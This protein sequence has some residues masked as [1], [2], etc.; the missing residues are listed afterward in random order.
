M[1]THTQTS[2]LSYAQNLDSLHTSH[3]YMSL[4]YTKITTE[5]EFIFL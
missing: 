4:S 1:H 5:I 3:I 2:V